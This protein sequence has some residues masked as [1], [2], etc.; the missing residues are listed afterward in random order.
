M[1]KIFVSYRRDDSAGHDGRLYGH[2]TDSF[3]PSQV[4][5]RPGPDF[6][7]VVQDAVGTCHV[8]IAVC[9]ALAY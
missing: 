7:D 1:P 4:F 3:G 9:I 2:I 5:M 8:F 6:V